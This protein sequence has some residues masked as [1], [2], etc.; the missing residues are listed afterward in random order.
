MSNNTYPK[1]SVVTP[2]FNQGDYIERT[3]CSVLDQGYPNLEY[4]IIDG[5]STD[6]S[7]EIIKKYQSR[8]HYWM[9]EKDEGMYHAISKGFRR[10]QVR[11]CV[12]SIATMCFGKV[13]WN[14]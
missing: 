4:V 11:S 8:L 5:G 7:V 12:G 1:I 14:I 6:S 2:N 10:R 13:L 9:S 3:I